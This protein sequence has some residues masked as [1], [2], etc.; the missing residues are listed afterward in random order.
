MKKQRLSLAVCIEA[1]VTTLFCSAAAVAQS[2]SLDTSF[3]TDGWTTT[4]F[5]G[6]FDWVERIAEQPDGKLVAVG[7]GGPQ[8]RFAIARYTAEGVLDPTFDSDGMRIMGQTGGSAGLAVQPDGKIVV[9]AMY[10]GSPT[11]GFLVA[12]LD[13]TGLNDPTFGNGGVATVS[14]GTQPHV[15]TLAIHLDGKVVV[16]GSSY[17]GGNWEWA[18]ARFDE[19]GTLDTSFGGGLVRTDFGATSDDHLYAVI[20]LDDGKVLAGGESE[21]EAG[22]RVFTLVRYEA[23]GDLD[24]TFG[25]GG[26]VVVP[27]DE[28]F[29]GTIRDLVLLPDN[30]ILAAGI[31]AD[32]T[33]L[34]FNFDGSLDDTFGVDGIAVAEPSAGYNWFNQVAVDALGRYIVGGTATVSGVRHPSLARIDEFGVLDLTFGD[35]GF[36]IG[37]F[38][39]SWEQGGP[40]II[41]TEGRIVTGGQAGVVNVDTDFLLARYFNGEPGD[42]DGDGVAT[43]VDNC[44]DVPNPDQGDFDGDGDGDACDSDSDN[45]GVGNETD[46][47][48]FTPPG[49]VVQPN[50]TLQS[51]ADGDCDSDLFDYYLMQQEFTGPGM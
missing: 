7:M 21:N 25:D 38:E 47:C 18:L 41:T 17:F 11:W 37:S 15:E 9:G 45:D 3:G 31:G 1:M 16:A 40:V 43:E 42:E 30:K 29:G 6:A 8:N 13:E 33:L 46:V 49:A 50:G 12:R 51:D 28:F 34:R 5:G 19:D 20:A 22:R 32:S 48:N 35:Q 27:A 4:D 2:G 36:V 23:D 44:P 39:T 26:V 24:P 10:L 14:A